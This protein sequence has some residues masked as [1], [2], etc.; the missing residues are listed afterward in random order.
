MTR[1][2]SSSEVEARQPDECCRDPRRLGFAAPS[3]QQDNIHDDHEYDTDV[4]QLW[5]A[6][7]GQQRYADDPAACE[8]RRRARCDVPEQTAY[9]LRGVTGPF[10]KID[11]VKLHDFHVSA[12]RMV[13]ASSHESASAAEP[14]VACGHA[15][16]VVFCRFLLGFG[17]VWCCDARVAGEKNQ[18]HPTSSGR[19]FVD[20]LSIHFSNR[21]GRHLRAKATPESCSVLKDPAKPPFTNYELCYNLRTA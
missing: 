20:Q 10:F 21:V 3:S 13:C 17:I 2:I 14:W 5:S 9:A 12:R 1:S 4:P 7:R 19:D 8:Y 16:L 15:L 11:H 6:V 18:G